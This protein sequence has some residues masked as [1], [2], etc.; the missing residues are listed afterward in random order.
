MNSDYPKFLSI[1]S[2]NSL[3]SSQLK[4]GLEID[5]LSG[6]KIF[7]VDFF[8]LCIASVCI[9]FAFLI[10]TEIT[11]PPI[12]KIP[13]LLEREEIIPLQDTVPNKP[14]SNGNTPQL[15]DLMKELYSTVA[16][17][18]ED[19]GIFLGIEI[20]QLKNLK[21]EERNNPQS[22]LRE[23]LIVWLRRANPPSNWTDIIETLTLIGEEQ[24]ASDLQKKYLHA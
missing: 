1:E 8:A 18:W 17:K 6:I 3:S 24:L 12:P 22:C 13:K 5:Q 21:C 19:I 16:S 7:I 14:L 15:K 20:G 9:H 11:E 4:R 10:Y 2:D 23:M